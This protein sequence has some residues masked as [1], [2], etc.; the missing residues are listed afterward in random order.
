M[1]YLFGFDATFEEKCE[2]IGNEL[3]KA[4]NNEERAA[5]LCKMF[6]FD[7]NTKAEELSILDL[8]PGMCELLLGIPAGFFTK[9]L[10]QLTEEDEKLYDEAVDR[11][12]TVF[13]SNKA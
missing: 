6:G 4:S 5:E 10:C 3:D 2:N 11:I 7:E 13:T 12:M 8:I 1:K 9:P